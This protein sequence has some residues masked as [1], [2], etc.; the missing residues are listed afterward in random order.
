MKNK[1]D[2]D[3]LIGSILLVAF[4]TAGYSWGA[5]LTEQP[6]PVETVVVVETEARYF[7][8]FEGL[9]CSTLKQEPDWVYSVKNQTATTTIECHP[10][11]M[12]IYRPAEEPDQ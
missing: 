7:F 4:F 1:L 10:N 11:I 5:N 2:T 8:D 9:K 12:D 6:S 3:F